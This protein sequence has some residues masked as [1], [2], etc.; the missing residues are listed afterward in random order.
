M[1]KR[2]HRAANLLDT[3]RCTIHKA[4]LRSENAY[5]MPYRLV[6]TRLSKRHAKSIT[7]K[8]R[9]RPVLST[10]LTVTIS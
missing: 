6:G 8:Y 4:N 10:S 1:R 2:R 7:E 9:V 5:S 3:Y